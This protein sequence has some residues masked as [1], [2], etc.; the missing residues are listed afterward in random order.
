MALLRERVRV[1]LWDAE[2]NQ[3]VLQ[4]QPPIVGV[5]TGVDDEMAPTTNDV[6]FENGRFVAG[7]P[8][9]SLETVG[10]VDDSFIQAFLYAVVRPAGFQ[11]SQEYTGKVVDLYRTNQQQSFMLVKTR[12][13]MFY[14]QRT[15]LAVR[16]DLEGVP[17]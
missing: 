2:L 16:V 8:V 10:N 14:E 11:A 7:I 6:L 17:Q 15:S 5:V 12:N 9:T 13:G 1:K 3:E 4:P